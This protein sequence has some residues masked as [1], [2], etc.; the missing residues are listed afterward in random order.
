MLG[1]RLEGS[2]AYMKEFLAAAGVPTAN[3]GVFSDEDEAIAFLDRRFA[4]PT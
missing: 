1:A 3:F 2:K 4:L